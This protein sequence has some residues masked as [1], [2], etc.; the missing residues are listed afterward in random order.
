VLK[1]DFFAELIREYQKDTDHFTTSKYK[2]LMG[3]DGLKEHVASLVEVYKNS[4]QKAWD[5]RREH[6]LPIIPLSDEALQLDLKNLK[7]NLG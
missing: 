4:Q 1:D 7:N 3:K 2:D 6:G 5:K